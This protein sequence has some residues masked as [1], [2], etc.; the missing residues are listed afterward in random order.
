M[1]L[2]STGKKI[3]VRTLGLFELDECEPHPILEPFTYEMKL[4]T[5]STVRVIFPLERYDSPPRKPE[6]QEGEVIEEKSRAW[7]ALR[8][9]EWYW[10]A[11]AN[12]KE[13]LE[14][15]AA[16]CHRIAQFILAKCVNDSDRSEITTDE[17]W[18]AVLRVALIPPVTMEL[19]AHT[20]Q[21]VFKATYNDRPILE[22]LADTEGGPVSYDALKIWQSMTMTKYQ[23]R[24]DT[25]ASIPVSERARMICATMLPAW[26][27]DLEAARHAKAMKTNKVVNALH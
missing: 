14:K 12:E 6:L 9:W 1:V 23:L 5:G 13:N 17:D 8:E 2:M 15:M 10:L 27:E 16:Y 19:I 20:I 7:Y 26:F 22:A 11:V 25:F 24:E 4:V 3:E 18:E 21:S